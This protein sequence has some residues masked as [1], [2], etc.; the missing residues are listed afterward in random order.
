MKH[1]LWLL[2]AV[3]IFSVC[4]R[5]KAKPTPVELP[6]KPLTPLEQVEKL[7]RQSYR[8]IEKGEPDSLVDFFTAD[9]FAFGLSPSETFAYRDDIVDRVRQELLPLGLKGERIQITDKQLMV[10]LAKGER[11]AWVSDLPRVAVTTKNDV[12][13][14]YPRLTAHAVLDEKGWRF[15]AIHL[16]TGVTDEVLYAADA[17]KKFPSPQDVVA[18][19]SKD[20]DQI[21]GLTKRM[22]EDLALKV[23]RVSER[24]EVLLLG[25]DSGEI[26]LG[27]AAFKALVKPRLGD[28]KKSVFSYKI[29]GNIKARVAD[30]GHTGF[31]AANVIL[32]LGQGKKMQTLPAFRTLWVFEIDGDKISLVQEHQSLAT[33]PQLRIAA[34]DETQRAR[35]KADKAFRARQEKDTAVENEPKLSTSDAGTKAD[36]GR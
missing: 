35:A 6:P 5:A 34:N 30:D 20:A 26:Y 11:S 9:A 19:R 2:W 10:G 23:E 33:S 36:A 32:R 3:V 21:V 18:E 24:D 7:L 25:T 29:D 4:A 17:A 27:G 1:R 8:L 15:D 22:L 31:V 13:I 12:S 14:Y 28:I 16:S